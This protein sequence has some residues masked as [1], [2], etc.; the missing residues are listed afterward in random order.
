MRSIHLS[1]LLGIAFLFYGCPL[2]DDND[3][4]GDDVVGDDAADDDTGGDDAADDDTGDDDAAD[5]DTGEPYSSPP[6]MTATIDVR[7]VQLFQDPTRSSSVYAILREFPYPARYVVDQEEGDCQLIV[8]FPG[9]CDPPCTWDEIC[10]PAGNCERRPESIP[11]GTLTIDGL[12]VDIEIDPVWQGSY[13]TG[14]LG[15]ELFEPGNPVSARLSGSAFPMVQLGASGVETMDAHL[16]N[17]DW[18]IL[19]DDQP[20]EISWTPGAEPDASVQLLVQGPGPC[21]RCPI[22]AYISCVVPDSGSLSLS[23]PMVAAF[24]SEAGY[25][26]DAGMD[27]YVSEITRFSRDTTHVAQGQVELVV[28]STK[29]F[30]YCPQVP[31]AQSARKLDPTALVQEEAVLR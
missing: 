2:G 17:G 9:F 30:Y 3:T 23:Q 28:R 11:G 15:E 25:C 21:H 7:E 22:S 16:L 10:T 19:V 24:L 29:Q 5:D 12:V 8:H 31:R 4:S 20:A 13:A 18:W 14:D 6:S 27:C 26:A 1:T